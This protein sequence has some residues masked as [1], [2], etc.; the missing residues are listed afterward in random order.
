VNHAKPCK[1]AG[2]WWSRFVP[3]ASAL[4]MAAFTLWLVAD[5]EVVARESPHDDQ[6]F[7][8]RAACGYWFDQGYTHFSF[9]KEPVYPLFC[10]LCYYVGIPLRLATELVY[11]AAAGFFSWSLVR[12]HSH[13]WVGLGLFAACALHPMR[14]AVFQQTTA[15]ALYPSLLL[16][17]LGA[18]VVLL[19]DEDSDW[20]RGLLSGLALGLLWNVRPERPLAAMLLF[21]FLL[22]GAYQAWRRAATWQAALKHWLAAWIPPLAALGLVT[23]AIMAA[24]YARFGVFATADLAAPDYWSAY[25]ALTGIRPNQPL[26]CVPVSR[27]ARL[28]AY[29]ASPSFRE[30]APHLEGALGERYASYSRMYYDLPPGEI[31]GG[32]FCWVLRDA[33][34]AAGHCRSAADSEAFYRQ[35]ADELLAAAAEGKLE[36][37]AMLPF[38]VDPNLEIYLPHLPASTLKLWNRCWSHEEPAPLHE[39]ETAVRQLFDTVAHRRA[40]PTAPT[41][42]S[43]ARSCLWSVY[44]PLLNLLLLAGGLL[45]AAVLARR[46]RTPGCGWYLFIT[47]ALSVAGLSRLGLFALIDA[48]AFPGDL[49]RYLFPAALSMALLATWLAAEGVRLL[50]GQGCVVETLAAPPIVTTAAHCRRPENKNPRPSAG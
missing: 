12:R 21:V 9:I 41:P 49:V 34:A 1:G 39:H 44:G 37:R 5:Q 45:G 4:A 25:Q 10:W 46:R 27:E 35:V 26:R 2:K 3:L 40:V 50:Y 48:S 29:A 33:A 15:D 17:S 20:R 18:L 7:L 32:W 31:A 13:S 6:F 30:L 28:R 16:L 38:G 43:G 24:N 8:E 42:Q 11:L 23:L 22:L 19:Q 36:T 47:L 14:F